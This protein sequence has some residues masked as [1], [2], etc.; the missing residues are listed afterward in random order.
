MT[1]A[2]DGDQE[3]QNQQPF[4]R[5]SPGFP[6][7]AA[8]HPAG[9]IRQVF[10]LE[11]GARF[12]KTGQEDLLPATFPAAARARFERL[13]AANIQFSGEEFQ[14]WVGRYQR[15]LDRAPVRLALHQNKIQLAL[16]RR[17]GIRPYQQHTAP[18]HS[19]KTVA[20]GDDR[21][22]RLKMQMFDFA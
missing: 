18:P 1:G 6:L 9:D 3:H 15:Q 10:G 7:L 14:I 2:E 20:H 5:H 16:Q 19:R 4:G 8:G 11:I 13:E 12:V 17:P 22:G 21:I